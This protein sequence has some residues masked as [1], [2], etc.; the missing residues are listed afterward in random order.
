MT[1][2]IDPPARASGISSAQDAGELAELGYAQELHRGVSPFAAFASGF[3]FVSILTTVFALFAVG[4]GLGGPAFFFTWP[5]VFVV[6]FSVCLVFAELSG[7]FPIAG[8]IY[9]WS[10]RLAGNTTGW[11]AGWLMLVGYIVS[12]AALAIAMQ[13]VLP[14]IWRGFQLIPGDSAITTKTG[15]TNGIILGALTIVVCTIIS[16]A[17]VKLMGR[18]T[19]VGVAIEIVGVVLIIGAMFV[20]AQRNPVAAV[21]STGGHGTGA[22]YIGA[23]VASMVMAAYVMYGFD[24]AA[25]LSEETAEPRKVCPKAIIN[26]LLVSFV[27]GGLMILAALMAAPSLDDPNLAATGIPWVITSQLNTGLGKALLAMVA[28]AIF[29]ATLAIQASAARVMF[30]MARDNRLP[31]GPA[32][33]KVNQRTGTPMATGLAVSALSIAVLLVNLGQAGAFNALVSVSVVIVYLA[34]CMVTVP[35]LYLRVRGVRLTYGKPVIDLGKWGIP[36]NTVAALGGGALCLNILWPRAEVYDPDGSSWFLHYFAPIF[37]AVT[38]AVGFVAF[39]MIKRRN[40]VAA[41]APDALFGQAKKPIVAQEAL[42]Q[43]ALA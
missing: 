8:A 37:L 43:E 13:S 40:G 23:F 42:A 33:A 10:R 22:G 36:V 28:V 35:A 1:A 29:S 41:P 11:F 12:V 24:S 18:I 4:F 38:L 39:R 15:A 19:T 26:A 32:L 30:S 21:A 3:S 31:F 20:K 7:K 16:S 6:Q 14:D 9:Q 25:E 5:I 27:G 2:V 34:Y 17:G